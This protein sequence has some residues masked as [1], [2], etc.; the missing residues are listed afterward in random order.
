MTNG[1]LDAVEIACR[2]E[3]L[4]VEPPSKAT[5]DYFGCK[6][7]NRSAMR[8]YLSSDTRKMVYE[9]I[10]QGVTLDK[11]VA[12]YVAAGMKQW[13]MEMGA[14]HYTHWFQPLT[15]GTA[16]K[17]DSFAEPYGHDGSLESF[18]GKLLCQQEPDA[19]SFPNGG[20]RNTFEARGYTAWDP[21]SPAFIL[22][23]CLCIPTVFISYNGEALDYKTPLLKSISAV[24]KA[25]KDV[26]SYF[27]LG[28]EM[29]QS[30]LGWEQEYFLVDRDLFSMRQDL[31][32]T[33]RTLQGHNSSKNQQLDDH[34]FGAIPSRVFEFMKELE[35]E[36]YKLGI[37]VKTRHNEVAPNQFEIAPV[38]EEAN[39]A[40]DHN[41]LLMSLMKDVAEKHGFEVLLHEKPYDGVNGSGKHCNWSLGT[42]SGIGL[43]SP[44]KT[45]EENLRFLVFMSN[46]LKAVYDNNALLKASIMTASNAH[47]LGANEAPPAI[48][49]SFLGKT[50]SEAF[51]ELLNSKDM[52]KIKGKKIYSLGIPQIPELLV[53]NTDRNRT[54]PFAFTGNRFEF[55]AV[56]S[57]ANCSAPITVLNTIVA[58]QLIKFKKNVDKRIEKG[59]DTMTAILNETRETYKACQKI[60]FDGNGYSE[61]W[62]KEAEKRKLDCESSAPITF[63]A[64]T[65]KRSIDVFKESNVLTEVELKARN[66]VFWETYSKKIE[67]EAR[68][69]RDM[70]LNHLLPV[71]VSYKSNLLDIIWKAKEVYGDDYKKY[72]EYESSQVAE[73][74]KKVCN[75][76]ECCGRIDTECDR[77]MKIG[78]REQAVEFHDKVIPI[79]E[80]I[81][82]E[83]DTLEMIIDDQMWP[84]PKYRELLFIS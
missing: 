21:S 26:L 29:V 1:R 3:P 60:C 63:D 30:Y 73:I 44:G 74:S 67:I 10:E 75:V 58:S 28:D 55:R 51:T 72:I 12:E 6:V 81:R 11:S 38:Y 8:K 15:G 5:S 36:A 50:V 47:R 53:D 80:K 49:S 22:D 18:S 40:V 54:S 62:K 59:E 4:V 57:S 25:T 20:L 34:Y 24:S 17:H 43:L 70:A 9:S 83:L 52:V 39:L 77:L 13:A 23:D 16:E 79:M 32:M 69:L 66:E 48:I 33:G 71:A 82:A 14:T 27:G 84:M 37:P 42:L 76:Y 64:F 7:F 65:S 68:T 45:T 19:S 46:I 61:E 41:L 35:F 56:G 31:M 2:K 78:S